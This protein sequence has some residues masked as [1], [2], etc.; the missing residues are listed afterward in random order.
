[1]SSCLGTR[2]YITDILLLGMTSTMRPQIGYGRLQLSS[3]SISFLRQP[4]SYS[5]KSLQSDEIAAMLS[6]PSWSVKSLLDSTGSATP[7]TKI[8]QKQLHHLLRL[9]ALPLPKSAAEEFKM[10]KTLESQLHFVQAIQSIDT[11]GIKPLQSIR[12]ESKEAEKESEITLGSLKEEFGREEVVG[13]SRRIKRRKDIPLDIS[14]SEDFDPLAQAS[15]K[16]GRY[17]VVETGK[18]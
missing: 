7:D 15:K 4:Y 12:D 6:K 14:K 8:S 13:R 10:I 3:V 9:S 1:M 11:T 16:V 5:T 2:I 18:V 17:I